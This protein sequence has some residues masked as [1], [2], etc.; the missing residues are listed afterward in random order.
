M[1]ACVNSQRTE[2]LFL[3]KGLHYSLNVKHMLYH[4]TQQVHGRQ[5][6]VVTISSRGYLQSCC[7]T[8]PFAKPK[9]RGGKLPPV[10]CWY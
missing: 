6:G 3:F 1:R 10:L 2:E 4:Y 7:Q 5:F 9:A 8:A